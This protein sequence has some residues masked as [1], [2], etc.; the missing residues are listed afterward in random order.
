MNVNTRDVNC[1]VSGT[2]YQIKGQRHIVL[3]IRDCNLKFIS[4]KVPNKISH[5]QHFLLLPTPMNV[6]ETFRVRSIISI[7]CN[8]VLHLWISDFG[9]ANEK[10]KI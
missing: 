8:L 6:W 2:V 4:N 3:F 5:K 1:G 9:A 7:F 10:F